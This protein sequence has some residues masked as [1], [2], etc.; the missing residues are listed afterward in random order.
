MSYRFIF[1][2]IFE[3]LFD[4][5]RHLEMFVFRCQA[6]GSLEALT[7]HLQTL[8]TIEKAKVCSIHVEDFE[9]AN[10]LK[11]KATE[12]LTGFDRKHAKA[13]KRKQLRR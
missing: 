8:F 9:K 12:N 11:S 1:G 5:F 2:S 13:C 7:G 3:N 10:R 6:V 4:G